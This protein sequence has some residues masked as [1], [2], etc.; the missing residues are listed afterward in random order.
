MVSV[1]AHDGVVKQ[2]NLYIR[3]VR[4]SPDGKLLATGAD[5]P[6]IRVCHSISAF[7]FRLTFI[8][9]MGNCEEAD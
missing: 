1:L 9:D 6:R 3:C 2:E 8:T 5:D 7:S 4:F